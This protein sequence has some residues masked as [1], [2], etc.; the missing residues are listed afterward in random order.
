MSV[1][2]QVDYQSRLKPHANGRSDSQ[3]GTRR[4]KEGFKAHDSLKPDVARSV[5]GVTTGSLMEGSSEVISSDALT[6]TSRDDVPSDLPV[7]DVQI[8]RIPA[9]APSVVACISPG[10]VMNPVVAEGSVLDVFDSVNSFA[11]LQEPEN[12]EAMELQCQESARTAPDIISSC[13]VGPISLPL[14]AAVDPPCASGAV[15][16]VADALDADGLHSIDFVVQ[17]SVVTPFKVLDQA[18]FVK[19]VRF[20]PEILSAEAPS[21][22]PRRRML[23]PCSDSCHPIKFRK[24]NLESFASGDVPVDD[25]PNPGADIP[26]SDGVTLETELAPISNPNLTPSPIARILKK[27][28]LGASKIEEPSSTSSVGSSVR[29]KEKSR[30]RYKPCKSK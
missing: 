5:P 25:G 27:Y 18:Q 21:S 16:T 30:S 19:R 3:K 10:I 14:Q 29:A 12:L 2:I 1:E 17:S 26:P 6:S 9:E 4:V 28:S 11:I 13:E 15:G 22:A 24:S 7:S 20:A 23:A 8:N